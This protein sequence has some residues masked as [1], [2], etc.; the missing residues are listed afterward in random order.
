[1]IRLSNQAL[2]ATSIYSRFTIA[3]GKAFVPRN[4]KR[5][6][7]QFPNKGK[8]AIGNFLKTNCQATVKTSPE[9]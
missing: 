4:C 5:G 9:L 1:M 2:D 3:L 7:S 6:G 8:L